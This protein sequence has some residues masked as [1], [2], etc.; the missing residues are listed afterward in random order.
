MTR[1]AI[2]HRLSA[3]AAAALLVAVVGSSASAQD[4]DYVNRARGMMF[5][6]GRGRR[7]GTR[8][9]ARCEDAFAARK[10]GLRP[11]RPKRVVALGRTVAWRDPDPGTQ[12]LRERRRI[13]TL[14]GWVP[15]LHHPGAERDAGD[16]KETSAML[17]PPR[18]FGPYRSELGRRAP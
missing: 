1:T 16:I 14:T 2:R 12:R 7:G 9:R 13:G 6:P 3:L 10:V 15:F 17:P 8:S 4:W 11:S 5:P 18:P